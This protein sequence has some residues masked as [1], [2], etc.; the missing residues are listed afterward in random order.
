MKCFGGCET[1]LFKHII[2]FNQENLKDEV[3]FLYDLMKCP[4]DISQITD[5]QVNNRNPA[6]YDENERLKPLISELQTGSLWEKL[7]KIKWLFD[8]IR[9]INAIPYHFEKTIAP[10][11]FK[12]FPN[13]TI[14]FVEQDKHD[15]NSFF[16]KEFDLAN[17]L[18]GLD[19]VLEGKHP[20]SMSGLQIYDILFDFGL[21]L[22]LMVNYP[23]VHGVNVYTYQGSFLFLPSSPIDAFQE[24]RLNAADLIC[25][26]LD[27]L[28]SDD[29]TI[30]RGPRPLIEYI[31]TGAFSKYLNWYVD[32]LATLMSFAFEVA[33]LEK[34][35]LLSLTLS[36]ICVETFL[37]HS[38]FSAFVRKVV[39]FNLLD[40]YAGLVKEL[41]SFRGSD[42]EI[43]KK[44][45]RK[46]FYQ[47]M[48]Q[49]QLEK[50]DNIV[51]SSFGNIGTAC[52]ED[53]ST[54]L[55]LGQARAHILT[56]QEISELLRAY[57]NSH[58]GYLLRPEER[59]MI[60]SHDGNISN[61][62]PDLSIVLWH[63][64]LQDPQGFLDLF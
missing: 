15:L 17:K 32:H 45:L 48:I 14:C 62:L 8:G 38:S 19:H 63:A 56:E 31:E 54:T 22:S 43:W 52:Y 39:F 34:F 26:N 60:L 24:Y 29:T 53:V 2:T 20:Q 40:K 46:S 25:A 57:R 55:S 3:C 28:Y 47:G 27:L 35:H 5:H 16:H 33:D 61:A 41:S 23:K 11:F 1:V 10:F 59:K 6:E 18:Y 58:H 44:I 42:V 51:G 30:S 4:R 64:F 9:Y 7:F 36:R 13:G 21:S 37:V 50:I 12:N 49:K